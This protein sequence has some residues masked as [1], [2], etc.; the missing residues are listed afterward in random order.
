MPVT[1]HYLNHTPS[2]RGASTLSVTKVGSFQAIWDSSL[3]LISPQLV[4]KPI[5]LQMTL[6]FTPRGCR[7]RSVL[8]LSHV[9]FLLLGSPPSK[10]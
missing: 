2:V 3:F 10:G 9:D 8:I 4:S 5:L 1:P 7:L 6:G